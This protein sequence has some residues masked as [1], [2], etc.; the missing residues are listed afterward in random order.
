MSYSIVTDAI[1]Y[2]DTANERYNKLKR[3]IKY[4]NR[5]NSYEGGVGDFR[6]IFYD[7]D[8]KELFRSKIEL[9]GK[10]YNTLQIWVWGWS[11][12]DIGKSVTTTIR[13]VFLY[14]TDIDVN[15]PSNVILK[16]ELVTSR[17]RI[18]DDV[19]ID[20]HCAIASYLAKKPFIFKWKDFSYDWDRDPSELGVVKGEYDEEETNYIYYSFIMTPPEDL[21]D[22]LNKTKS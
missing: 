16:N 1:K 17:F 12:P 2:F 21:V 7:K 5:D 6:L 3:A 18:D 14:G 20:I 13:K 4:V 19:Q 9:L 10:Y 15:V 11:I 8:K 22:E